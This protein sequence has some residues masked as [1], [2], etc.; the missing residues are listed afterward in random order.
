MGTES[1]MTFGAWLKAKRA[2]ERITLRAFAEKSG[3]DPGNL[4]RYERGILPPPLGETL[5]RVAQALNLKDGSAD[6]QA[7]HDLAAITAGRIPKDLAED[8]T[9]AGRLPVLFR[10]VRNKKLSREVLLRLADKI[11]RG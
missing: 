6:W 9:L 10:V 8:P 1:T 4:S 2:E 3:I 5:G 7:F 11:R